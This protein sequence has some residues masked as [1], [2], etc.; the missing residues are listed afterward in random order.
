VPVGRYLKK[1]M[2]GKVETFSDNL[3]HTRTVAA[4]TKLDTL[5][6]IE[7]AEGVSVL[8]RPAGVVVRGLAFLA[9]I[10]MTCV[11]LLCGWLVC[12]LIGFILDGTTSMGIVMLVLF[13]VGWGY[14]VFA[15]AKYGRTL[16]KKWLGLRVVR[17]TGSAAGWGPSILRNLLRVADMMPA[18]P[19]SQVVNTFLPFFGFYIFGVVSCMATKR[20]QRIGDLVA[21]TIVIYDRD[22]VIESSTQLRVPVVATAPP[23]VLTREEQLAFIQFKDRAALW[24]DS[25]K[26]ELADELEPVLG[27]VGRE[28]VL[29]ALSVAAW[30]RES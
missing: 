21:G 7:L 16:G 27:A 28:G 9:D 10:M 5:Q 14:F 17:T 20:F 19:A 12:A 26:E 23:V 29:R 18:F 11:F 8:L 13:F 24:S 4:Q 3:Q 30:L 15:E 25:R 1:L 22:S 2:Q 6:S